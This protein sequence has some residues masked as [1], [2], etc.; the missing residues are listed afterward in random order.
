MHKKV[1]TISA[2]PPV[3]HLLALPPEL[4]LQIWSHV[5]PSPTPYFADQPLLPPLLHT[6]SLIRSEALPI[7][8]SRSIILLPHPTTSISLP[9]KVLKWWL[10]LPPSATVRKHNLILLPSPLE[11]CLSPQQARMRFLSH[12]TLL[13]ESVRTELA[14]SP[15]ESAGLYFAPLTPLL[16]HD[17][18]CGICTDLAH[19]RAAKRDVLLVRNPVC[20]RGVGGRCYCGVCVEGKG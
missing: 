9:P 16:D 13:L 18:Q 1:K 14:S 5:L 6:S 19:R 8:L 3:S 7:F 10:S 4:R 20:A 12:A 17:A 15:P 11:T 2:M